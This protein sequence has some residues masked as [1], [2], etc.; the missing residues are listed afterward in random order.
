VPRRAFGT[1]PAPLP[2]LACKAARPGSA[3]HTGGLWLNSTVVS[4][5]PPDAWGRVSFLII[6][7]SISVDES[8]HAGP[9]SIVR[10]GMAFL[11]S[12]LPRCDGR[13]DMTDNGPASGLHCHMLDPNELPSTTALAIESL[14]LRRKG[15][16]QLCG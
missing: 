3:L 15:A 7:P 16:K 12:G 6:P 10:T 14:K 13:L 1:L 4:K 8:R 2:L 5:C 11:W 9:F